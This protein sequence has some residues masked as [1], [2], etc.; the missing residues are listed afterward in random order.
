MVNIETLDKRIQSKDAAIEKKRATMEKRAATIAKGI[1]YLH[2]CGFEDLTEE[3]IGNT[4]PYTLCDKLGF[5]YPSTNMDKVFSLHS[6]IEMQQSSQRDINYLQREKELLEQEKARVQGAMQAAAKAYDDNLEDAFRQAFGQFHDAY[7]NKMVEY[8]TK[9][10]FHYQN[11]KAAWK[12]KLDE[13]TAERREIGVYN[14]NDIPTRQRVK[15]IENEQ[16]ELRRMLGHECLRYPSWTE[17]IYQHVMEEL[18]RYWDTSIKT[19]TA[20][21]SKMGLN[22]SAIQVT[23]PECTGKG[24]EVTI[25]DGG[26]RRIYARLIWAAEDSILVTPHFRYIVTERN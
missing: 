19:L 26:K 5:K 9:L 11:H 18:E 2:K 16:G 24:F 13:L 10:F 22:Q 23:N 20:K 3:I 1:A 15:V 25:T 21:C 14:Y 6:A 17:Y 12:K 8:H 4:N 7:I